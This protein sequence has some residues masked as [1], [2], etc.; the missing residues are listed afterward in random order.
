MAASLTF[1]APQRLPFR[2]G[3]ATSAWISGNA[4]LLDRPRIYACSSSVA[5]G[6]LM[7][8]DHAGH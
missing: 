3:G 5:A 4:L 2:A 7:R 6:M 1:Q 8:P